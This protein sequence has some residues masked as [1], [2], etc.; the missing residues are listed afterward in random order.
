M[1]TAG[2]VTW[3]TALIVAVRFG[4]PPN[5][6]RT[7]SVSST[8]SSVLSCLASPC[9]VRWSCTAAISCTET[10][11]SRHLSVGRNIIGSGFV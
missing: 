2:L 10:Q 6:A 4:L 1:A 3:F 8:P 5:S 11:S 9:F 7:S